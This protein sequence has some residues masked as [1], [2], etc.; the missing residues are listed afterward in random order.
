MIPVVPPE[1][2]VPAHDEAEVRNGSEER[3]LRPE[4]KKWLAIYVAAGVVVY[5]IVYLVFFAGGGGGGA[6]IY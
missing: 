4:W 1:R 6:G 5:I 3:R 2:E